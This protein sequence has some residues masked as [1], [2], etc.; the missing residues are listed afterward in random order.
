[1]TI[2]VSGLFRYPVKSMAGTA[3]QQLELDAMGGVNDRRWMLVDEHHRFITQREVGALALIHPHIEL[4]GV[5]LDAPP[6]IG[7][8]VTTPHETAPTHDVVI[9]DDVVPAA[10]AGEEAA[11]WCSDVLGMA[12]RLVHIA[13]TAQ[14]PLQAKY[15]GSLDPHNRHVALSDGAP[16]LLLSEA[17]LEQ[18]ND[19]LT[20]RTV[21]PVGIDRFR[22]NVVLSGTTA[23]DEDTWRTIEIGGIT[24]GVGSPCPRCVIPTIDQSRGV[25]A[26]A[27]RDEPGGEPLR[28]LA[29][30]RR[31][32]SGVMFG[33]NATND[34]PG[35]IRLGDVV[36]VIESR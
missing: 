29:T 17:S 32:G 7:L 15:A 12:C 10:D 31:Q 33:M 11:R 20:S 35:V 9:W 16:L 5:R 27:L 4:D 6:R 36:K 2:R 34:T 18:L 25:R 3:V 24:I 19:Q 22:P 14:R 28:T 13:A 30:Y 1:M 26:S 8:H 23:H 21:A